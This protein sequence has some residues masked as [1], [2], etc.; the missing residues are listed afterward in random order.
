MIEEIAELD[1]PWAMTFLPDGRALITGRGGEL[2]LRSADGQTIEV[3]GVPEVVHEGQGGLGDVIVAPD[4]ASTGTVYLS[5]AEAGDRRLRGRGGPGDAD[6]P[7]AARPSST[8]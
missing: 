6:R 8:T 7:T 1:E 2:T 4:F 5:W 3:T